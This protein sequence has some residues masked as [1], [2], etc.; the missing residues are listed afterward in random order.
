LKQDAG[1]LMDLMRQVKEVA[2]VWSVDLELVESHPPCP[3]TR[4]LFAASCY[5]IR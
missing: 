2:K 4:P 1:V 3:A 5:R